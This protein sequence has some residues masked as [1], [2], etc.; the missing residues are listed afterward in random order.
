MGGEHMKLTY[1]DLADAV[2]VMNNLILLGRLNK[3]SMDDIKCF[4]CK[5]CGKWVLEAQRLP[6]TTCGGG[7]H[8]EIL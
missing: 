7:I 1:V 2:F 3:T 6:K 8:Y 4:Q 5:E